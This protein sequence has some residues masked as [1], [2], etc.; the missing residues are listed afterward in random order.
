MKKKLIQLLALFTILLMLFT[1]TACKHSTTKTA[2]SS[3]VETIDTS[4]GSA[5]SDAPTIDLGE[6]ETIVDKDGE[7]YITPKYDM[8]NQTISFLSHWT[9]ED[10]R[11]V[12]AYLEKY[13][14]P[15]VECITFPY[16]EC[17]MKL[18]AMV[19]A[20][21]PPD[22]YKLRM[23]DLTTL[24]F[25]NLWQDVT[26]DF[27][28][29]NRNWRDLEPFMPYVTVNGKVLV[30]PEV[31]SNQ[32][33][34]FYKALFE[35][36]GMQTPLELWE[37]GEWTKDNFDDICRKLTIREGGNTAIYG[38]GFSHTWIY[39]VFAMFDTN[40]AVFD[41]TSYKSNTADPKL[42]DAMSYISNMA[43]VER[44]WCELEKA[45]AYFASGK[46]AMLYGGNFLTGSEPYRSMNAEGKID[47]VP[48]PENP[49]HGLGPRQ[50]YYIEGHAIPIGAKNREGA[51]AFIEIFNFYKQSQEQDLETTKKDLE[52][53]G[54]TVEQFFRYR[55]CRY[56][57]NPFTAI[58]LMDA[59][60]YFEQALEGKSWYE[61]RAEFDPKQN[62]ILDSLPSLN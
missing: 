42:A 27:D 41:G 29:D 22:V 15:Q 58:M 19:L 25:N 48:V 1:V 40:F 4:N 31:N 32:V 28:W 20:G 2:G 3:S 52:V 45:N 59:T 30:A 56:Y 21:D 16:G 53:A 12:L 11:Y 39:D 9:P 51:K 61:I 18:Q 23:G 47:F 24:L 34:W 50:D 33:I 7:P 60:P 54:I 49:T 37:K 35:E 13:S 46:L 17:G 10:M 36:Y 55:S 26:N 44:V 5:S 6:I 38:F 14:G 62:L 57:K 8:R 43:S